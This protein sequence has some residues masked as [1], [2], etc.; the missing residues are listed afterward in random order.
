MMSREPLPELKVCEKCDPKL[1]A[2]A[3]ELAA[4][5][6]AIGLTPTK[7]GYGFGRLVINVDDRTSL[8]LDVNHDG[9]YA[10]DDLFMLD[11]LKADEVMEIMAALKRIRRPGDSG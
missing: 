11:Y 2:I 9:T 3:D 8:K 7:L 1:G 10:V 6:T 5:A 4:K